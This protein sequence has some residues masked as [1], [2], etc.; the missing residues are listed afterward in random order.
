MRNKKA[1][2]GKIYQCSACGKR[3]KWSYGYTKKEDYCDYDFDVSCVINAVLVDEHVA[4]AKFKQASANQNK[5][6]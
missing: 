1:P 3:S 4:E 2:K 6:R 5:M